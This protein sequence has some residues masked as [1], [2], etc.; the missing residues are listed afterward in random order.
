MTSAGSHPVF[1]SLPFSRSA[2]LR[3]LR[4]AFASAFS[5]ALRAFLSSRVSFSAV[6]LRLVVTGGSAAA[7]CSGSLSSW[8]ACLIS[9]VKR[10]S[11]VFSKRTAVSGVGK[12]ASFSILSVRSSTGILFTGSG[13]TGALA[14]GAPGA[15]VS[16]AVV[17]SAVV[18]SAASDCGVSVSSC[19]AA[20]A[21]F[22]SFLI[23]TL[24]RPIR[25]SFTALRCI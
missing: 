18:S 11:S 8:D 9:S 10:I 20:S 14:I 21:A 3:A 12:S 24:G 19:S 16:S 1:F 15:A 25:E 6:L 17:S 4:S 13:S 7:S 5:L 22:C 23:S 2:S